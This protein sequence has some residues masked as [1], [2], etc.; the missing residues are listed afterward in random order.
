MVFPAKQVISS[1]MED[2]L[3]VIFALQRNQQKVTTVAIAERMNVSPASVTGMCKKLAE[4]HLVKHTPYQGV[5]LTPAGEKVALEVIRHHRLL[6]LYLMQTLGFGWDQVH[7][8]AERLEHV[9]SEEFEDKIDEAL[10][11]PTIDPHG[12]PIPTRDGVMEESLDIPLYE[13]EINQTG[14]V[15]W[16]KDEKPDL[17]RYLATLGIFPNVQITVKD[18]APFNGPLLIQVGSAEHSIGGE[19]AESVYVVPFPSK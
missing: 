3:K 2:Y 14:I 13:M 12:H 11:Y 5:E 17:L 1:A 10:G 18:K 4:L 19:A 7:E 15:V 8:E 16:V 6:E 9:I